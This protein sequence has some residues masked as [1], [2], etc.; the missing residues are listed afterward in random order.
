MQSKNADSINASQGKRVEDMI[1]NLKLP[2]RRHIPNSKLPFVLIYN[3]ENNWNRKTTEKHLPGIRNWIDHVN[4]SNDIVTP[5]PVVEYEHKR[6]EIEKETNK[7]NSSISS[8][9]AEDT[10]KMIKSVGYTVRIWQCHPQECR[11]LQN[12]RYDLMPLTGENITCRTLEL[13]YYFLKKIQICSGKKR[14]K[15]ITLKV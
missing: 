7:T 3:T 8:E 5:A 11:I 6:Y 10:K 12:G 13:K 14:R 9:L 1:Q 15:K 4:N 2:S